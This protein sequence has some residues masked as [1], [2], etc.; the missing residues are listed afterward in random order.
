MAYPKP[1]PVVCSRHGRP[2]R[3]E[4][5]RE[6]NRGY[7]RGYLRRLRRER[8][9][10]ALWDRA[11]ERARRLG[12]SFT[13]KTEDLSIP[14]QCPALGIAIIVGESRS[15][16]S[17]SLDRIVPSGGYVEGNVRVISDR[18]NRLKSNL[19]QSQ[20]EERSRAAKEPSRRE[21][22]RRLAAYTER[23]ALLAEVRQKAAQGGKMGEE[24]EKIA[25]W[26]DRRFA[27]GEVE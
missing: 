2:R 15:N 20:L 4:T 24:W 11:R 6:C 23:E 1:L 14:K 5:C 13:I 21:E 10:K 19:A 12:L 8:P 9:V 25:S 26:L 22:Y 18:A 3:R 17:P 16:S 27:A 7:M